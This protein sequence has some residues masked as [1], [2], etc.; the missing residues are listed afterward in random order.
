MNDYSEETNCVECKKRAICFQ[1]LIPEEL[2]F[3][4]RN[5]TQLS[6]AKGETICKQGAYASYLSYISD[7][8]VKIYLEGPKQKNLNLRIQKTSEF[9]GLSSVYGEN[10]YNY[11][12]A[13]LTDSTI[14]LIDKAVFKKILLENG[15]FASE[16]IKLFC[17]YEIQT[18]SKIKSIGQKQ[19]HGRLADT[20][21]YLH[22]LT[23]NTRKIFDFIS[24][25]EIADFAGIS[26]ES[27]V[28]L[29]SE[30]KTQGIIDVSGRELQIIDPERLREISRIG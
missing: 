18:F 30:F 28:R 29:I 1:R 16:V 9:I 2:E 7:G 8:L 27:T 15:R 26:L 5:K 10:I 12:A 3:I 25:K 20:L 17:M 19:M 22:S 21:I 24:R 4:N 11:S 14:C 6:Y 13:A 23:Y